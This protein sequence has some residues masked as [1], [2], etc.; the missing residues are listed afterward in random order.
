[1][2]LRIVLSMLLVLL[3]GALAAC[4]QA[5]PAPA[6]AGYTPPPQASPQAPATVVVGRGSLIETVEARGRVVSASEALL[7]FELEGVLTDVHVAPG[8]HVS[9]GQVVAEIQSMDREGRTAEQQI[10]DAQ[11]GFTMAQLNLQ[12]VREELAIAEADAALCQQDI[13]RAQTHLRQAQYDYELASYLERPN[14]EPEEESDFTRAQRWALEYASL[15]YDR[16]EATCT[17]RDAMVRYRQLAVSLAQQSLSHAQELLTRAE[18]RAEQAQLRAPLSGIVISWEKRI[19]EAVE[20]YDP[21]GAVADPDILRLEAWAS[22]ENVSKVAPGQPVS[23]FLDLRPDVIFAAEV[24]DVA[25][26]STVWQGKNVYIVDIEFT[27]GEG[28]PATIRTGADVVIETRRRLD[29]LLVPN[30]AI[31]T[32]G[33]DRFVEAVRGGGRVKVEVEV[34]ISDGSHTEILA[35]LGE[36]EEIVA[37]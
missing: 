29:V 24:V 34:G 10:A 7:S 1:V 2:V 17:S 15:D 20:P 16:A 19:G 5:A 4:G 35:G 31:Y 6:S 32:E 21:I 36:G 27:D 33:D 14:K 25:T 28:I 30:A 3:A 9:E 23:V 8:D 11:H 12:L 13:A 37:P 22:E 26:E 18:E